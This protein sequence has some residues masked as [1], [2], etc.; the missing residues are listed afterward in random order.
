MHFDVLTIG[1]ALIDAF[2]SIGDDEKNIRLDKE[3]NEL[4]LASGEKIQLTD[5]VFEVGGNA[6]NVAV[7]LSRLGFVTGLMAETGEDEFS[8]TILLRLKK[9]KVET[10]KV[11]RKG[12]SSFAIG[13]NLKGERTLLVQHVEREHDFSLYGV[14][15]H[16]LYL[17]SIGNDWKHVYQMVREYVREKK[18]FLVLNPGTRQLIDAPGFI[19]DMLA[20]T[21]ILFINK[22]EGFRLIGRE[23]G[24]QDMELLLNSLHTLGAETVVVTDGED[25]SYAMD[26]TRTIY[27]AP[28]LKVPVIEKTGAGDSYAT[29]F[30]GAILSGKDITE[31]MQWGT[32]SSSSVIGQVGSQPGLLTKKQMNDELEEKRVRVREIVTEK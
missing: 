22:E 29:G 28:I 27:H 6:C 20:M 11:K 24:K 9:E 10:V 1:N 5:C 26:A 7:G 12:R 21:G 31:A 17:T 15:A 14:G 25:G 23:T 13:I 8:E 32:L 30:L 18:T 16:C 19:R 2:L 4:R 3:R